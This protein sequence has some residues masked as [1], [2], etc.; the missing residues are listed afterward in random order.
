MS[1]GIGDYIRELKERSENKLS[2]ERRKLAN[3]KIIQA[4]FSDASK[5]KPGNRL[6]FFYSS[7]RDGMVIVIRMIFFYSLAFLISIRMHSQ[8]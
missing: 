8:G 2:T 6:S 1:Q 4:L 5:V 3:E 7:E